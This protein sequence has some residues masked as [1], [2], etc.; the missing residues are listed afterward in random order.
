MKHL[1]ATIAVTLLLGIPCFAQ[2]QYPERIDIENSQ[3]FEKLVK[4]QLDMPQDSV[5]SILGCPYKKDAIKTGNGN[6]YESISYRSYNFKK[7]YVSSLMV[8]SFVFRNSILIMIHEDEHIYGENTIKLQ[9]GVDLWAIAK[10]YE[11][12]SNLPR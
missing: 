12:S 1:L 4:V 7:N 6:I 9:Q 5:L 10:N 3:F 8:Y 11:D 2:M